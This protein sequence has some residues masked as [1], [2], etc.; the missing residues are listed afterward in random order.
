VTFFH[1]NLYNRDFVKKNARIFEGGIV[2]AGIDAAEH[3][4]APPALQEYLDYA[5]AHGLKVTEMTE[6]GWIAARQ[7]V[8][9]LKAAGP[10]FTWA[11]F[12]NGW[13]Q[14]TW[15]S[16]GGLVPPIDW[17]R[18]HNDPALP[19]S[20]SE[21]ECQNFVKIHNGRF[22]G[23]YDD[24]GAKPWLCFDG[25][26]PDEWEAPVNLSFAGKPFSIADVRK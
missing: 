21:F 19:A 12:V 25:T 14:Q 15:Y 4:P 2:L 6:Q 7:F 22:V 24:G 3:T 1:P 5:T 18:E 26:K 16:N 23:I 8:N 17:T 20:R 13:N 9:A 10:N 11:N